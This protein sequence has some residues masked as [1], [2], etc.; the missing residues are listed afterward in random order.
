MQQHELAI[1]LRVVNDV[2]FK[3]RLSSQLTTRAFGQCPSHH[4]LGRVEHTV[5][6]TSLVCATPV[7]QRPGVDDAQSA[8]G[9]HHGI[10]LGRFEPLPA[11]LDDANRKSGMDMR[12][13][14]HLA[15]VG[16]KKLGGF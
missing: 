13:K 5:A 2:P 7:V 6:P 16:M 8:L 10:A 1:E 11:R 9:H 12:H 4:R 3:M 14:R 15:V